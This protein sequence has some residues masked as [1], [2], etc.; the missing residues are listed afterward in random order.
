LIVTNLFDCD[1][2]LYT[3]NL[4]AI[5][6][7]VTFCSDQVVQG[8]SLSTPSQH[9]T[10]HKPLELSLQVDPEWD[11]C[12]TSNRRSFVAT[13][14]SVVTTSTL[15]GLNLRSASAASTPSS[16]VPAWTIQQGVNS[17]K[18]PLLALNT[19]GLTIEDAARAVE[20]SKIAGINHVDFHPG[21]ERDGVALFLKNNP[22]SREELFLNTKIRKP[23]PG[24]SPQDAATRCQDQIEEDLASLGLNSVDMLMLRDSPDATV[25]QAQWKVLENALE[26]GQT[27]SIGVVNFCQ[28]S[29]DSILETARIVPGVNYFMQHVGMG[30]DPLG[31]RSYGEARGIRTFAYG[32]VGEPAPNKEILCNPTLEGIAKNHKVSSEAVAVRWVLQSGAAVSVRPTLQFSLGQSTCPATG[33]CAYGIK[34]RAASFDW[35]LSPTEMKALSSLTV[36]ND[37]PTLFSSTGCPNSFVM[38]KP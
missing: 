20:L 27:R 30:L 35:K 34:E 22:D 23:P 15:S 1:I 19:V 3:G 37:N 21:R 10:R 16:R 5:I 36:P 7:I 9:S 18:F 2:M 12:S 38:P 4:V 13:T 24:T 33:D 28:F 25:M 11:G 8:F 32:A 31:L 26:K 14:S 29:L 6:S 17:V